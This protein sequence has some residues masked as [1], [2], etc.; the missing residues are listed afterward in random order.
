MI[1]TTKLNGVEPVAYL[2]GTLEAI[3]GGHPNI[4][5]VGDGPYPLPGC[6]EP[7]MVICVES[8]VGDPDSQQGVKL[9]NQYLITADGVEQ[10]STYPFDDRL[11]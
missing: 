8:Y 11:R 7:G 4:P 3:A 5:R 2:K 9:E 6:F 10:M 1:E